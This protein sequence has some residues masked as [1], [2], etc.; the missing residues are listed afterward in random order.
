MYYFLEETIGTVQLK[1]GN[2]SLENK[3]KNINYLPFDHS[4]YVLNLKLILADS[5]YNKF[6][7]IDTH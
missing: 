5:Y 7:V 4:G 3:L 2:Y 1:K 6:Q